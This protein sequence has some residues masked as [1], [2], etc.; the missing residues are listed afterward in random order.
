MNSIGIVI[1]NYNKY[2]DTIR[3]IC[4]VLESTTDDYTIYLVDNGSTDQSV[5][6]LRDM[7]DD[8]IV[9]LENNCNLGSTGGYNTGIKEV[10]SKGH[11]YLMLLD[12]DAMVDEK[13]IQTMYDYLSEHPDVGMVGAKIFHKYDPTCIQQFGQTIDLKRYHIKTYYADV[14]DH[15]DLPLE[16]ECNTMST[17][18]VMLPCKVVTGVGFLSDQY[19]FGWDDYDWSYRIHR[20]GYRLVALGNAKVIHETVPYLR[21]D[22]TSTLYYQWRNAIYFFMKYTPKEKLQNMTF[23]ILSTMYHSIYECIFR[24][25]QNMVTTIMRAYHDALYQKMGA[26]MPEVVLPNDENHTRFTEFFNTDQAIYIEPGAEWLQTVLR[27]EHE[28]INLVKHKQNAD[29]IVRG[30][31][32]IFILKEYASHIVYVDRQLNLMHSSEDEQ[33]LEYYSF[34]L[35]QFLYMHQ[36]EFLVHC[37][38]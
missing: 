14:Y 35:D 6:I 25:E 2:E 18:A 10:L 28:N 16:V 9:I 12:N 15:P 3:C 1:C 27:M 19:F 37:T 30:C 26:A 38:N 33:I 22:D 31:D 36:Q 24:D 34:G 17:T 20:T 23:S 29:L 8:Q 32:N 13:A 4:S 7:F 5:S 11:E 21:R